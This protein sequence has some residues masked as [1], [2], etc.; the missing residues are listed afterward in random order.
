MWP[1]DIGFRRKL[2][3][4]LLNRLVYAVRSTL[5]VGELLLSS[6]DTRIIQVSCL[7]ICQFLNETFLKRY[8]QQPKSIFLRP[9]CQCETIARKLP[10]SLDEIDV[11]QSLKPCYHLLMFSPCKSSFKWQLYKCLQIFIQVAQSMQVFIL[12]TLSTVHASLYIQVALSTVIGS[13]YIQV[14]ILTV[15]AS[16][17]SSG[18]CTVHAS[19]NSRHSKFL[20]L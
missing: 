15:N 13:L 6:S 11:V 20:Y 16:L 8:C 1:S 7:H 5:N 17:R 18:N 12:V 19:F 3:Y 10:S 9:K 2:Y 4:K 14:V